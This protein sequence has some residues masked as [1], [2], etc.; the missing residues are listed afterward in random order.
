[1]LSATNKPIIQASAIYKTF[2]LGSEQV[3]V[4]TGV[5]LTASTGDIIAIT[6]PSGSGKSTLLHILGTLDRPTSGTVAVNGTDLATLSD[7]NLAEFRNT[8]IGFVF[9]FHHLLP[10]FTVLENVAMP[11]L[12]SRLSPRV[13]Y[14]RARAA[15]A[16]VELGHRI[17]HKPSELSGGE[18]QRAAVAR[19]LISDPLIV[20]ADE[21][22]GNLDHQNARALT[23]LIKNLNRKKS[24]TF[25]IVTHNNKVA[26]IARRRYKLLDGRL[27][28]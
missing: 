19:A 2:K 8:T 3:E 18:K 22:T 12:I 24:I 20:L 21:P 5:D 4:L 14:E 17:M 25:L 16:D 27:R 13:A 26:R 1:M 10:E 23:E 15:I 11:L 28:R 7:D 6:G 9:Q